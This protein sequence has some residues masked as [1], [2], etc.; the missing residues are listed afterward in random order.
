MKKTLILVVAVLSITMTGCIS[1]IE[2]LTLN[3]DGSGTFAYTV[4]LDGMMEMG[5]FDQMRAMGNEEIGKEKIEIDTLVNIYES[6]K[7]AGTLAKLDDADF[8]KKVN[9]TTILSESRKKGKIE[10]KLDFDDVKEID[11]FMKNFATALEGDE[12]AG[13][14]A[15]L[16]LGGSSKGSPYSVSKKWFSKVVKRAK[17]E[18]GDGEISK[19]MEQE[20]AEMYK[21]MLQ[22]AE[23]VTVYNLPKKAKKVSNDDAIISKDG[24]KVTL[25]RS[26][27]DYLE[28]KA[29]LS[30]EIKY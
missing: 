16:G 4:D 13:M 9:L 18:S 15:Q 14:V 1:I 22:S 2:T 11:Y 12:T 21:M 25:K 3:K 30:N 19:A 17:Q 5:F 24:K 20:G 29:D 26:L 6:Q 28:G 27:L 10:F 7:I 23:Y 8:W